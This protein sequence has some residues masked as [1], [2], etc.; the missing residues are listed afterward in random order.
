[1]GPVNK[2]VPPNDLRDRND[3]PARWRLH[4]GPMRAVVGEGLMRASGVVVR[5]VTAQQAAE[6]PFVEHDDVIEAFP[7]NRPDDSLGERILPGRSRCDEDLAN[8]QAFCPPYEHIAVV[9]VPIAEQVL[10]RCLFRKA[11]DQLVGGPG[12]GG[13]VGD[14]DM[15]QL[16]PGVSKDQEYEEQ[17]EGERWDDEEIDGDNVANMRLKEGAPRRGWPRRGAPHVFGNGEPD[18]LIA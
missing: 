1:M 14:G 17:V 10:G 15:D 9:G 7:S 3:A 2:R 8:P 11:L 12:G 18:D 6:M 4:F 16:S 5:E 13:V